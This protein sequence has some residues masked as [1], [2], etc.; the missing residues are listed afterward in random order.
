MKYEY[1]SNI[2]LE[3]AVDKLAQ[4]LDEAGFSFQTEQIPTVDS[5]GRVLSC[6]HY[7][8][9][10]SPHY[11]SCAM[12]GIAITAASIASASESRPAVLTK[13]DY[14]TVD[15]GDPLPEGCDCVIMIEQV[16]NNE[17]GTIS[18]Y[19]SA[20][21]WTN[22][23]QIGEDISMGDMVA[24][25]YTRITPALTGALLASGI[26]Q[27]TVVRTPSVAIIPTG[28]EIV[29]ADSQLKDGDIPEYNSA[30][31][32]SMLREWGAQPIVY[33]IAKDDPDV[34]AA[35]VKDA[36]ERC[37]AVIVIAGSSA[38]RDD[39]TSTV[40]SRLGQLV[41]HG[42]AIKP[43]KPAVLG[44]IGPVP[45]FGVPGYPVS[46]ILIMEKVVRHFIS[47]LTMLPEEEPEQ[48]SVRVTRKA[49]S[50][51]KYEEFIRCQ[52][53]EA[54]QTVVAVPMSRGAGIVTGFAKAS[55]I[56]TVPQNCEGIEA[57][58]EVLMQPLKKLSDIR[59]TLCVTGSHDPLI[60]EAADLLIRSSGNIRPVLLSSSHVGS[61][62]AIMAVRNKEAHLG[63]IHLLDTETGEYNLSYVRKYFPNGGAVLVRGVIREQGLMVPKHNPKGIRG[64]KDLPGLSYVN[65][66]KGA[67]TRILLDYL[68]QQDQ[69]RPEE[70]YGYTKEEYTHTAVAAAI[71]SGTADC[72]MGIFSAAHTY[73]LDFLHLWDEEYDFLVEGSAISDPRVQ[74]FL[75]VLRSSA[76]RKRLEE[77]GG[78]RLTDPGEVIYTGDSSLC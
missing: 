6:A 64:I 66:Q 12:D 3:E 40:L 76:F 71:A 59:S 60:D 15:T 37:D 54:G 8:L 14:I 57:G 56:I 39:Y 17:D 46:G 10:S 70:I 24:P 7:A 23:R 47:R 9:R 31:F 16:V 43:G 26:M 51:L 55:G 18:L 35:S 52:A 62:G 32:S 29:P 67:G 78:Y 74:K 25:S 44:H 5:C 13:E 77:M 68:L 49:P 69:I 65:R 1:L 34:I 20:A 50:S 45:F 58:E 48:L 53:A 61:M 38:G 63:G 75:D 72:G 19:S 21:P 4:A 41:V 22:V 30:I 2:P 42:I 73:D 33:P 36:S 27:V 28:D 11:L